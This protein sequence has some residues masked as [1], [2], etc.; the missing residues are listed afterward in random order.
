MEE[1][2]W[3]LQQEESFRY[4]LLGRMRADCDYYLFYGNR[5]TKCL[6]AGNVKDQIEYM[7]NIWNSFTE[8]AKPEWLIWEGILEYEKQMISEM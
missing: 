3:I 1:L 2:N 8:D 4:R 7:K 5:N 6:W